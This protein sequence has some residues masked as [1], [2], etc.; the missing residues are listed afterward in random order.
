MSH[1]KLEGL[2]KANPKRFSYKLQIIYANRVAGGS[3][4]EQTKAAH[5][6]ALLFTQQKGPLSVDSP[7]PPPLVGLC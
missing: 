4:N 5:L 1:D 6:N 2:P 3:R 7:P